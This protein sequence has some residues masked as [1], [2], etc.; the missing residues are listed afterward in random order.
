MEL[1]KEEERLI[2]IRRNK[3]PICQSELV[4]NSYTEDEVLYKEC[5]K[6]TKHYTKFIGLKD[7]L[8]E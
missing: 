4:E 7:D 3:C 8:N 6:D 2:W 5:S 1:T